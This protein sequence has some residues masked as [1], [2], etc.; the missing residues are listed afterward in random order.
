[1][2]LGKLHLLACWV[3]VVGNGAAGAWSLTAIRFPKLRNS[4]LWRFTACVQI[5][6]LVQVTLA[7]TYLNAGEGEAESFHVFYG[8]LSAV[9]VAVLYSYRS[10]LSRYLH[11]LYGWGGLFIMGLGIRALVLL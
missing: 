3:L 9:T 1:M 5:W 2:M 11:A 10:Q 4:W 8:V 6:V 7:A